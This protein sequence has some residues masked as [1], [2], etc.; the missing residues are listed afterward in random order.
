MQVC[1]ILFM[2]CMFFFKFCV[3][4]LEL[5]QK[6]LPSKGLHTNWPHL[7]M[8]HKKLNLALTLVSLVFITRYINLENARTESFYSLDYSSVPKIR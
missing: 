3:D 5:Y 7:K 1:L 4:F 2:S 8:Q 6:L